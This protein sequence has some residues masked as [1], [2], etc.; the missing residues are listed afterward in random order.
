LVD[1][2]TTVATGT[3]DQLSLVAGEAGVVELVDVGAGFET[4][5]IEHLVDITGATT[6]ANNGRFAIESIPD[7]THLRFRNPAGKAELFA[8]T[9]RVVDPEGE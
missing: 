4:A 2:E 5:A 7:A 6:A 1:T 9:W 3:G 8:G